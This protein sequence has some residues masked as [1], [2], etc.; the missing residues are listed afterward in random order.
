M[1]K[2]NIFERKNRKNTIPEALITNREK[3]I[4]EEP[5]QKMEKFGTR[6]KTT[7][8]EKP[9][10]FCNAP[11]WNPSHTN[12]GT[13]QIMQHLREKRLFRTSRQT[14]RKEKAKNT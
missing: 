12:P 3:E 6:P 7:V 10:K 13:T 8:N 5:I 1:I 14:K 11:N 2:Q 4:K 9:C